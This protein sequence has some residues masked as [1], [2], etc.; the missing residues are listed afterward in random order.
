MSLFTFIKNSLKILLIFIALLGIR[1][2]LKTK[3]LEA[4]L[5]KVKSAPFFMTI[6]KFKNCQSLISIINALYKKKYFSCL[7]SSLLVKKI[8][9]NDDDVRLNI[10]ILSA[11]SKFESHAWIEKNNS[12]IFGEIH[13]LDKYKKILTI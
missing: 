13:D 4:N 3:T 8:L 10:G 2:S 5:K 6:Y 9:F 12:M 11:D 1:T 7:E